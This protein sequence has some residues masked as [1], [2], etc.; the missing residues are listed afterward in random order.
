MVAIATLLLGG[1][2]VLSAQTTLQQAIGVTARLADQLT[3]M[4]VSDVDFGGIFIPEGGT[5]TA[6]LDHTGTVT[7][8]G[9][10]TGQYATEK[11]SAGDFYISA[12]QAAQYSIQYPNNVNLGNPDNADV[13]AYVPAMFSA[14]GT[15][16]TSSS[17][18]MYSV[19]AGQN[20]EHYKIG[21][22]L[23]IPASVS[24][25]IYTGTMNVTVVWQ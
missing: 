6:T 15:P 11:W 20:S 16:I 2:G 1:I 24:A 17:T 12:N 13:L 8:S 23:T 5:A 18:T 9:V 7:M 25:G 22:A 21:G 19:T 3:I 14:T 4:K 10:A